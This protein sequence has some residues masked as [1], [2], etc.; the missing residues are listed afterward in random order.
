MGVM[1]W[2]G[3]YAID[4]A[5]D[6][7]AHSVRRTARLAL[8]R[9]MTPAGYYEDDASPLTGELRVCGGESEFRCGGGDRATGAARV[10]LARGDGSVGLG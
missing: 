2:G 9:A 4:A 5:F 3:E 1:L 10:F 7:S 8:Q 6:P